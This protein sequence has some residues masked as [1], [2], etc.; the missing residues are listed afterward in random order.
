MFK[1]QL[2]PRKIGLRQQAD[3]L[4]GSDDGHPG[5]HEVS[6]S[7]KLARSPVRVYGQ[8]PQARLVVIPKIERLDRG[9]PLRG[10]D[11]CLRPRTPAV[12]RRCA[13]ECPSP[14]ATTH[15]DA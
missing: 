9:L 6:N 13:R 10:I 3:R 8:E 1:A 14:L 2:K 7:F 5:H 4:Y 11:R 12:L 15:P